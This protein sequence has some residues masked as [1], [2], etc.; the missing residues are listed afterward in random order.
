MT[1]PCRGAIAVCQHGMWGIITC[2]EP[3]SGVWVGLHL[4]PEKVGKPWSSKDPKVIASNISQSG[5]Y[6]EL[7]DKILSE[8][9]AQLKN[10]FE[11]T[12]TEYALHEIDD[13][14]TPILEKNEPLI[15]EK[16][17]LYHLRIAELLWCLDEANAHADAFSRSLKRYHDEKMDDEKLGQS[18][19][20]LYVRMFIDPAIEAAVEDVAKEAYRMGK[21]DAAKEET[22]ERPTHCGHPA[23]AIHTGDEGT[24][25][26][27][28]CADVDVLRACLKDVEWGFG[29]DRPRGGD[30]CPS[31]GWASVHG[32]KVGCVLSR[33]LM[34]AEPDEPRCG[35]G[36]D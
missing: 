29:V 16:I 3:Q 6:A 14:C 36:V 24:S 26:C 8:I 21:Q 17:L 33:V 12:E 19:Y 25:F 7:V 28:W 18:M 5:C 4:S 10:P 9:K 34:E 27:R 31:C 2:D 15:A 32:H 13:L 11:I 22:D 30:C 23:S 1:K 20:K 35:P